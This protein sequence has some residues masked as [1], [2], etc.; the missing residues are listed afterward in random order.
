MLMTHK[1][2]TI[3]KPITFKGVGLHSAKE[4][5]LTIKPAS[6]DTGLVFIRKD[7]KENNIIHMKWSNVT[8]TTLCTLVSNS[9]GAYVS[10]VEHL[11]AALS[12]NSI[13]NAILELNNPEVPILD[14][15]AI[16]FDKEI[17]RIGVKSSTKSRKYIRILKTVELSQ[18]GWSAKLEP[19]N[20]RDFTFKLDYKHSVIG[21]D[22]FNFS[23]DDDDF[24]DISLCRTFCLKQDVET[25]QSKG[26]AKGGSLDNA[27]IVDDSGVVNKEG[28][29]CKGEFA[30]H[31]T[32]DSI[33]DMYLAGYHILGKLTS[34]K[35][36]HTSN[37]LIL[38]ALF[39]DKSNYE[40]IESDDSFLAKSNYNEKL[41]SQY[42]A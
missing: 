14:G 17:K 16:I 22:E 8:N 34:Y 27:I 24:E 42:A 11:M 13:D 1:Q 9:F 33:G 29:R 15:S 10:T 20:G 3:K 12:A 36:G 6:D 39:A 18:D 38:R 23:L 25:M 31:K 35:G 7:L 30:K 2:N 32:L 28:L 5:V 40:I 26:L 19:S 21:S 4:A 37:N 41:A